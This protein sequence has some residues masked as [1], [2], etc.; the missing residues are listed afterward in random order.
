MALLSG[1]GVAPAL[2]LAPSSFDFGDLATGAKSAAR[3]FV[4]RNDGST[5]LDLDRAAI[6]GADLDQFALAGDECTGATLAPGEVAIGLVDLPQLQRQDPL[7]LDLAR[8]GHI[9][10][11]GAG[12][13]GL[14]SCGEP[15]RRPSVIR[16]R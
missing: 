16:L 5:D 15:T 1:E 13:S 6:V 4:V 14:A 8:S 2:T 11:F 9:A 3:A 12:N 7:T 10:V